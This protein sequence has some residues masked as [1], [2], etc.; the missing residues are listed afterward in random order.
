M[1]ATV[2]GVVGTVW[3]QVPNP[4][5]PIVYCVTEL[6]DPPICV[7]IRIGDYVRDIVASVDQWYTE[8][9]ASEPP[10]DDPSLTVYDALC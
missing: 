3:G 6:G 8:Y 9:C 7:E 1:I 2:D 4:R 10:T 5:E